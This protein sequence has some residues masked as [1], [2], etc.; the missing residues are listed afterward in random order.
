MHYI[1]IIGD[2]TQVI[3]EACHTPTAFESL[4]GGN[5][6]RCS[7]AG[8]MSWRAGDLP[9]FPTNSLKKQCVNAAESN[10]SGCAGLLFLTMVTGAHK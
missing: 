3:S 10:P 5:S 9:T 8:R 4:A 6:E 7:Y 2:V 1:K